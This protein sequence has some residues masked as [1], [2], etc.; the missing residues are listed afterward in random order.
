M[1]GKPRFLDR[2]VEEWHRDCWAWLLRNLGG[3]DDL[4]AQ[5][6]VLPTGAFFPAVQGG[7]H[8]RAEAVF[9]QVKALMRMTDW[10]CTLAPQRQ[11]SG[12]VGEFTH[13]RPARAAAGTF[14]AAGGHVVITY[15][16]SMVTRPANL[17]ATFAHELAHYL[18]H[19]LHERPPGV[20]AEP[21]LEELATEM[22]VA[23]HGFAIIAANGA[24][25]FEQTQDFGRQGWSSRASGYFS[26]DAWVFALAMFLSLREEAPAAARPHLKA[27]LG[28]KLDKA[29]KRLGADPSFLSELKS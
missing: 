27:H 18:L 13:L 17:V 8:Q 29:I 16:S 19:T 10:P 28:P 9:Q 20:E 25:E 7:A 21:Q 5:R 24:F 23:Y 14:T 26:E 12:Q 6:L 1:W 4:R 22:T 15:D 3:M 2:D 11:T